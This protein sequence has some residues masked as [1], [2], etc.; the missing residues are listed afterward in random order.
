MEARRKARAGIDP[1]AARSKVETAPT[2]LAYAEKLIP[3]I[4]KEYSNPKHRQQWL[5]T[6]KQYCRPIHKTLI[7]QIGV[8]EVAGVL[9]PIWTTKPE[10]AS[11]VRGRIERILDAATAEGFRKGVNPA[12]WKG[13]LKP[14]FSSP[15]KRIERHHAAMPY[16]D[17]PKFLPKL[18]GAEGLAPKAL[19]LTIL[20]ATRSTET[21][22]AKI[23]EFDI[24]AAIWTIPPERMKARVEHRVPLS[25]Q[26]LD[27]VKSLLVGRTE[28]DGDFLFPGAKKGRPLSNMAMAMTLRRMNVKGVTTHGFRSSFRDWAG[29][30]TAFP[31]EIAEAALAHTIKDKAEAAYRRS[32]AIER[33]RKLMQAWADYCDGQITG[34]VIPL[35]NGSVAG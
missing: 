18:R 3:E 35:R 12:A 19:E 23:P 34:N 31:R 20:A 33:R 10:T 22:A 26:A 7:D 27:L 30:A 6:I 2:F 29:D 5:N 14:L 13:V 21:L 17:V 16:D 28:R 24:A 11:R 4:V 8:P 9:R 25:T 32:D 1:M 15:V